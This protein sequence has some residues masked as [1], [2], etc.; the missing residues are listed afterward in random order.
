MLEG[1]GGGEI[2]VA[3]T[4]SVPEFTLLKV[5]GILYFV[6]AACRI[7]AL[8]SY[9]KMP[10]TVSSKVTKYHIVSTTSQIIQK[11]KC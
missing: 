7:L 11:K 9:F 6:S 10:K 5:T 2:D 4:V 1:G 8:C 3:L